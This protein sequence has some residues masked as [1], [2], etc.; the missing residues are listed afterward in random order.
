MLYALVL[1]NVFLLGSLLYIVYS[2]QKER[3]KLLDRIMA[4]DYKEFVDNEKP[5]DNDFSDGTE[6]IVDLEEAKGEIM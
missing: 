5:E 3:E 4:K 1:L 2:G 6:Q